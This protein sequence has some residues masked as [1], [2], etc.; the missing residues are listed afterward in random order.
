MKN[1]VRTTMSQV[2]QMIKCVGKIFKFVLPSVCESF[3]H[4][5]YL[6]HYIIYFVS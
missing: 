4:L 6:L 5:F 2:R 1:Y 3:C